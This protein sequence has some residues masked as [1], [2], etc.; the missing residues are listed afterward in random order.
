MN[1][2]I[3]EFKDYKVLIFSHNPDEKIVYSIELELPDGKA[4]LR[5]VD[6]TLPANS[7]EKIG[8][9]NVYY[10]YFNT[11]QFSPLIDILRNEGPLYFYFNHSNKECYITTEDEPVGEGEIHAS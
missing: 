2:I 5:F 1:F 3:E 8:S 6:N 7:M 11:K 4:V 10:G 9:K